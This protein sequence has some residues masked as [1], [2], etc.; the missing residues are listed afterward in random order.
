MASAFKWKDKP[1][2]SSTDPPREEK[3][4]ERGYREQENRQRE[5]SP[6]RDDLKDKFG[7]N[8][9]SQYSR[10]DEAGASKGEDNGAQGDDKLTNEE[11]EKKEK[12]ERKERK[13]KKAKEDGVRRPKPTNEPIIVVNVNNR[14]GTREAIPCLASDLMSK[15]IIILSIPFADVGFLC[16]WQD[17]NALCANRGFQEDG[18]NADGTA[19]T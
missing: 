12:K 15:F 1:S 2:A 5:R 3:R 7:D 14:L 4:L 17:A 16:L 8:Y 6:A 13:K 10:R 19:T 18:G 11:R 9:Q